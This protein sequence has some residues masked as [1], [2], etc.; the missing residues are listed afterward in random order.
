MLVAVQAVLLITLVLV[1]RADPS[2]VRIAIGGLLIFAGV[3]LGVVGGL[4]LGPALTPTPVPLADAGL[5]TSG[6]YSLIRHPIYTAV[7]LGAIGFATAI[8][9]WWTW[10]VAALLV[11]FFWSKSRWEDS[12]LREAYGDAW[13]QWSRRTGALLPRLARWN[14]GSRGGG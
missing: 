3:V 8:G 12:L 13:V 2:P 6:P 10:L 9:T 4:R 7:L 14:S 5:R 1:P 11:L